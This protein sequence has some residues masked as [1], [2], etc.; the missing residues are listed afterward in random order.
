MGLEPLV[1]IKQAVPVKRQSGRSVSPSKIQLGFFNAAQKKK[2]KYLKLTKKK[3][4]KTLYNSLVAEFYWTFLRK[5]KK[6]GLFVEVCFFS[7]NVFL[8]MFTVRRKWIRKLKRSFSLEKKLEKSLNLHKRVGRA[9]LK[10]SIKWHSLQVASDV[11]HTRHN[12]ATVHTRI[13]A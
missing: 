13:P 2:K 7:S 5:E 6:E 8:E 10:G 9:S 3:F 1:K 4:S 12:R 11:L